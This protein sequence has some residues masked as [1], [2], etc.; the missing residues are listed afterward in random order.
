[1]AG[2]AR[3]RRLAAHA[4]AG[5]PHVH[6]ERAHAV[7]RFGG[8]ATVALAACLSV[9]C[10]RQT[11]KPLHTAIDSAGI[12]ISVSTA[13]QWAEGE[14]WTIADSPHVDIG[15][16]DAQGHD[17]YEVNGVARL[18]DG[19]IAIVNSGSSEV[20]LFS[21]EGELLQTLGGNGEGPGEFRSLRR[22][23]VLPGDSLL[24][25]DASLDRL[26]LFSSGG[27]LV[28]TAAV[29]PPPTGSSPAPLAR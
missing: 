23:F 28:R 7:T 26:T 13:P 19:R 21:P 5:R 2:A 3:R 29:A 10:D 6:R 24:V 22:A 25:V 20:R 11:A 12:T 18:S 17:L 15:S 1:A 27:S 14:G 8:T 16:S 9:A 4:V